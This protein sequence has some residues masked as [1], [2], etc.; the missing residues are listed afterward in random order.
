M[1]YLA[2]LILPPLAC[3]LSADILGAFFNAFLYLFAFAGLFTVP[4]V[5][6]ALWLLCVL[7]A[8][9]C[10]ETWH[11]R[12]RIHEM[13]LLL[14]AQGHQPIESRRE[15]WV[16]RASAWLLVSCVALGIAAHYAPALGLP[17]RSTLITPAPQPAAQP[18]PAPTIQLPHPGQTFAE[19]EA[20]HGPAISK[21]TASGWATWKNFRAQFV[22]GRVAATK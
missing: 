16:V 7:H 14:I 3:L 8:C 20:I 2:A 6:V 18:T 11:R 13:N 15:S 4:L 9:A 19:V 1:R 17:I 22:S 12:Q 5:G 21:D 10:A